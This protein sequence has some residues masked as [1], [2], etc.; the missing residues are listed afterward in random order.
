MAKGLGVRLTAEG[1]ARLEEEHRLLSAER[2]PALTARIREIAAYEDGT[3]NGEAEALK[4]EL[5]QAEARVQELERLLPRAEVI[6]RE[7]G[8]DAVGLGSRVTL[9]ADDGEVETWL[10]VAPEEANA[11]GGSISTDSPVGRALLGCHLGDTPAVVT[12]AGT[13]VYT[14]LEVA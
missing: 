1:K 12:P 10:L 11:H 5:V 13:I 7:A 6:R 4:E 14:V 8:D 9:R 2:I 3:D